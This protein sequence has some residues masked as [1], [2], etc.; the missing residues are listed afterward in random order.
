MRVERKTR[1]GR[2]VFSIFYCFNSSSQSV[3]SSVPW[4]WPK[5]GMGWWEW[6]VGSSGS[7]GYTSLHVMKTPHINHRSW[8]NIYITKWLG[9]FIISIVFFI[10][11]LSFSSVFTLHHYPFPTFFSFLCFCSSILNRVSTS[12]EW[13]IAHTEPWHPERHVSQP[14]IQKNYSDP[15]VFSFIW[16]RGVSK[17][18]NICIYKFSCQ[19]LKIYHFSKRI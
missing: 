4:I 19:S 15:C 6:L 11:F 1:I 2:D 8:S 9:R 10:P 14:M 17:F 3:I 13:H 7:H 18:H 12:G 5:R 16:S